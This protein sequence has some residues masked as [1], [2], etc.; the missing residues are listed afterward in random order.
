MSGAW[1]EVRMKVAIDLGR[2]A[3]ADG[4]IEAAEDG[5]RTPSC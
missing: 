3:C 2:A 5:P 4:V 1:E